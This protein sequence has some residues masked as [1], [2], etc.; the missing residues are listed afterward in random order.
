[1]KSKNN[2]VPEEAGSTSNSSKQGK[3][4]QQYV[5]RQ[6]ILQIFTN[7]HQRGD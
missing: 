7:W 3:L 1:M 2:P 5:L 4:T 6:D